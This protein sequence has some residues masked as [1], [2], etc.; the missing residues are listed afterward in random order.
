M[1]P[2]R[3][4]RPEVVVEVALVCAAEVGPCLAEVVHVWAP[5][6]GPSAVALAVAV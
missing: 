6:A 5:A 3:R 1:S 4:C 2:A